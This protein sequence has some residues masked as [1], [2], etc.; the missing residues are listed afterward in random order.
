MLA[1][2]GIT[3]VELKPNRLKRVLLRPPNNLLLYRGGP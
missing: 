3:K 2:A 1:P